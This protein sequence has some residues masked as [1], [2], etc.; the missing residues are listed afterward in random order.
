MLIIEKLI[1]NGVED[2]ILGCTEIPLIKKQEYVSVIV[3]I[4]Q[5]LVQQNHLTCL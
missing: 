1:K 3:L 4:E 5:Q 2:V